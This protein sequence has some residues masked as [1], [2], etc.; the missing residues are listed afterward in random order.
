MRDLGPRNRGDVYG[1]YEEPPGRRREDGSTRL[2]PVSGQVAVI[3]ST[4]GDNTAARAVA[5]VIRR[6]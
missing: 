3:G 4:S 5:L 1:V 6:R 2:S